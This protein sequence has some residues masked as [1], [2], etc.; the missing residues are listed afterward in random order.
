SRGISVTT[1]SVTAGCGTAAS[2]SSRATVCG[3]GRRRSSWTTGPASP[4]SRLRLS[5]G[6]SLMDVHALAIR[7]VL[8][9]LWAWWE[10]SPYL[11]HYRRLRRAD[12]DP[13]D[14][15]RARQ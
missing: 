9:P 15:V 12:H 8:G 1:C 4:P 10:K 6:V 11:T 2:S 13:P 7:A 3:S 5:E 14:A